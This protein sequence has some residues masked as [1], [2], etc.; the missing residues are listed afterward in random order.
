[1]CLMHLEQ[2]LTC[3]GPWKIFTTKTNFFF[4][5]NRYTFI[6]QYYIKTVVNYNFHLI[7]SP[8]PFCF[9]RFI[10]FYLY[11]C[12]YQREFMCMTYMQYQWSPEE[13]VGSPE[14]ES[15]GFESQLMSVLG[16]KPAFS[17]EQ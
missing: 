17:A 10:Y 16:T 1:M 7:N 8:N 14:L 9:L 11:I 15:Q 5:R 13:G 6:N 12:V 2:G 3:E 4:T